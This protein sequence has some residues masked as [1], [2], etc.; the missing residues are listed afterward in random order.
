M[1]E[2]GKVV[3][4]ISRA[5]AL[6]KFVYVVRKINA[7]NINANGIMADAKERVLVAVRNIKFKRGLIV[8]QFRFAIEI[9][10]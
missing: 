3:I 10:K 9:F 1:G 2:T 4:F 6:A 5:D 7:F 8:G